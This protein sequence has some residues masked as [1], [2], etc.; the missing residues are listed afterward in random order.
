MI[1]EDGST[2]DEIIDFPVIVKKGQRFEYRKNGESLI[3]VAMVDG[4][5][6]TEYAGLDTAVHQE[7]LVKE[8]IHSKGW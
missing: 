7:V 2:Y 4:E 3:V 6:I 5:I 8:T 1:V